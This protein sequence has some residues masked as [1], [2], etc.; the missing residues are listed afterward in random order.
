MPREIW[1]FVNHFSLWYNESFVPWFSLAN[2][3]SRPLLVKKS[4][5]HKYT[6]GMHRYVQSQRHYSKRPL[7]TWKTG[8]FISVSGEHLWQ[9]CV[10]NGEQDH[11]L[12]EY[13]FCSALVTSGQSKHIR[14][15]ENGVFKNHTAFP[16]FLSDCC[17]HQF[18]HFVTTVWEAA[19]NSRVFVNLFNTFNTPTVAISLN[20]S[21]QRLFFIFTVRH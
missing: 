6:N 12:C 7:N 16:G 11:L 17:W 9:G 3:K 4:K 15:S 8:C 2:D 5:I 20:P 13:V 1:A 18:C 10:H 14:P 21:H 19:C